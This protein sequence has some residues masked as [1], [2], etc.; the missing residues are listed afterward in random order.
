MN[1]DPR[2]SAREARTLVEA[3]ATVCTECPVCGSEECLMLQE[4]G[5]YC[6]TMTAASLAKKREES[7]KKA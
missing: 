5:S 6:A 7:P 3:P 4:L 1:A 2:T